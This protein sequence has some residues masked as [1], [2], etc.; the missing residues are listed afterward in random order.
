MATSNTRRSKAAKKDKNRTNTIKLNMTRSLRR[1]IRNKYK[2]KTGYKPG[3]KSWRTGV[4]G[5]IRRCFRPDCANRKPSNRD[6]THDTQETPTT[7]NTTT[8]AANTTQKEQ[9]N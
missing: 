1:Q 2:E 7:R 3:P 8:T 5:P 9:K 6:R 4:T